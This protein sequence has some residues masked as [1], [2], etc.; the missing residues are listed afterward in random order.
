M[1]APRSPTDDLAA[2]GAAAGAP[3]GGPRPHVACGARPSVVAVGR[4]TQTRRG[5][6]WLPPRPLPPPAAPPPPPPPP[7]CAL[8]HPARAARRVP[9]PPTL[10]ASPAGHWDLVTATRQPPRGVAD[11]RRLPAAC[12]PTP[13]PRR[14]RTRA[15]GHPAGAATHRARA[16]ACGRGLGW[17]GQRVGASYFGLPPPRCA[18]LPGETAGWEVKGDGERRSAG[19]WQAGA[20]H[21]ADAAQAGFFPILTCTTPSP[22]TAPHA[23]WCVLRQPRPSQHG[24]PVPGRRGRLPVA[25]PQGP[26]RRGRRGAAVPSRPGRCPPPHHPPSG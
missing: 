25:L 24:R 10:P 14:Q 17:G 13:R 7:C 15:W 6:E 11:E 4:H 21:P 16:A 22:P 23:S 12:R 2:A 5:H 26:G 9:P 3:P 19:G 8:T 20:T 18:A 1:P